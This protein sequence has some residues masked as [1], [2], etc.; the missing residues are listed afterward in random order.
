MCDRKAE[1]ILHNTTIY[2]E[3]FSCTKHLSDMVSDGTS[4]IEPY[5]EEDA[6]C[7]HLP[8]EVVKQ[9]GENGQST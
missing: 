5:T 7:C 8:C 3:T 6:G 4:L 1:W 2:N 9:M